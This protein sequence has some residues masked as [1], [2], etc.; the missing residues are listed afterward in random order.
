MLCQKLSRVH[1]K[2]NDCLND[3]L[4]VFNHALVILMIPLPTVMH[5]ECCKVQPRSSNIAAGSFYFVHSV[6]HLLRVSGFQSLSQVKGVVF[7]LGVLLIFR[8]HPVE[9]VLHSP[10]DVQSSLQVNDMCRVQ[11]PH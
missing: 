3:S 5:V 9:H 11:F 1:F 8:E 10:N 2:L 7:Q 6:F 4:V